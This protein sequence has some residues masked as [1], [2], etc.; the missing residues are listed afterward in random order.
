MTMPL[1]PLSVALLTAALV[2]AGC[3]SRTSGLLFDQGNSPAP[4]PDPGN[5]G[6]GSGGGAGPGALPGGGSPGGGSPG[7]GNPTS[8]DTSTGSA[9]GSGG[10]SAEPVPE[11]GTIL[12]FGTGLTGLALWRTR[13][14]R[15]ALAQPQG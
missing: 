15:N 9:T 10:G 8:P 13:R 5:G 11:P 6:P 2:F 3:T 12:L 1:R 14:R 7:G 4:A